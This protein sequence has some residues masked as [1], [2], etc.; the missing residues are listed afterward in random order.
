MKFSFFFF[1]FTSIKCLDPFQSLPFPLLS[2]ILNQVKI[3]TR[4]T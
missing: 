4:T 3:V 1:S 2:F